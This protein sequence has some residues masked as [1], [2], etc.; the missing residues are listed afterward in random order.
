MWRDMQDARES[1]AWFVGRMLWAGC[2]VCT[3]GVGGDLVM[4]VGDKVWV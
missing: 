1:V 2:M 4:G 3:F